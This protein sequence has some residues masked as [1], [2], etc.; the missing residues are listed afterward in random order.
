[1]DFKEKIE[2]YIRL[3]KETLDKL[4][5]DAINE[6]MDL[7]E[8]ARERGANIF[9]CGNGGSA[10]TASHFTSDFNKPDWGYRFVCLNDNIPLMLAISNDYGYDRVF[11]HQ[12]KG[13]IT[14]EDLLV[15]ISGSGNS[16]NVVAAAKHA[17]ESGAKVVGMT[18]YDGG[19]IYK[20]ADYRLHVPLHNMQIAE[21]IH[22][23]FDHLMV[24]ILAEQKAKESKANAE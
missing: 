21:D 15:C 10:S 16:P 4:D 7:F 13:K 6:V 2:G 14:E 19:E 5:I 20:L 17:K 8:D 3:E 18:G 24:W 22:L 1:M 23:I 9:I 12:L 11:V